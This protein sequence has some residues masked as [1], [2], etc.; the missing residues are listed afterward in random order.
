[1]Q[2]IRLL[3]PCLLVLVAV[4]FKTFARSAEAQ[5]PGAVNSENEAATNRSRAL[6]A[7]AQRYAKGDGVP[8]DLAKA[9]DYLRQ[10]AQEGY[11]FAQTD[12]GSYYAKGRGVKKDLAAAFQWYRRAAEQGDSLGQ[13]C[14]GF[15]YLNGAGTTTNL[16]EGLK[17]WRKAGENGTVEAQNGLGQFY[18]QRGVLETNSLTYTQAATW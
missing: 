12:L 13:Y 15:C 6:Y 9:A 5:L 4:S 7:L 11:A 10:A 14:L 18:M 16:D 2:R 8:Q 1:M 3:V 17:W